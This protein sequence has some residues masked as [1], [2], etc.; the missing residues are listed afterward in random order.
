MARRLR[1]AMAFLRLDIMILREP[2]V[3]FLALGALIFFIYDFAGPDGPDDDEIV[4][5]RGQQEHLATT[6]IKTMN[7]PPSQREFDGVVNNW[8]LDELAYREAIEMGLDAND[9]IIRR[10]LR[11]KLEL[12][13]DDVVDVPEPTAEDLEQYL[14]DKQ[15]N[16]TEDA[17]YSLQHIFFSRDRRG[18]A[19]V[20]DAERA[21]LQMTADRQSA[22]PEELG[23]GL[24]IP[25]RFV[26]ESERKITSVFG[27]EFVDGIRGLETG[28]WN[29]PVHSG[30]GVH[31]VLIDAYTPGRDLTLEEVGQDVRRRWQSQELSK[32]VDRLYERIKSR[33][34]IIMEPFDVDEFAVGS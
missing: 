9:A 34:S 30:L 3:Q 7:R 16:Y 24:P 11:Q 27:R 14:R 2:L 19:A 26:K 5:T 6:F 28:Q 4:V 8:L 32:G 25:S 31:L 33:Y 15:E 23:D 17:V 18:A 13:A 10:R 21:L 1:R 12:L 22:H 29:G 20:Q